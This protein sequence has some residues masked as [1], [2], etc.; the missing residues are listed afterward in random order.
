MSHARCATHAL[1]S[2]NF[3]ELARR[4][5]SLDSSIAFKMHARFVCNR[6]MF[7]P[8]VPGPPHVG[9]R[10]TTV[11]Q[12]NAERLEPVREKGIASGGGSPCARCV[13]S[14]SPPCPSSPLLHSCFCPA[15]RSISDRCRRKVSVRVGRHPTCV[16]LVIM[17]RLHLC[18]AL[19][20]WVQVGG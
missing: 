15:R 6:W 8:C 4:A 1:S 12:G 13:R 5:A 2:H 16:G 10:A 18:V 14:L 19:R 3:S 17:V 11:A 9:S 7:Q 20:H